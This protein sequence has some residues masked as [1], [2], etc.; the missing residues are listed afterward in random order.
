MNVKHESA[1]TQIEL[2]RAALQEIIKEVGTSTRAAKI[3][4]DALASLEE[5]E[6]QE[7]SRSGERYP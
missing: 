2:L 5:L 1:K 6:L 4:R 3:A 7:Q